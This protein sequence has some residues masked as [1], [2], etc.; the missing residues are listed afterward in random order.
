MVGARVA[1]PAAVGYTVFSPTGTGRKKAIQP[2]AL[3]AA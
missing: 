1:L 3:L 2:S